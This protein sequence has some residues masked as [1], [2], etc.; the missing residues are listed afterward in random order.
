[1]MLLIILFAL[2][3]KPKV[4]N[5]TYGVSF[6]TFYAR[7]LGLNWREVYDATLD[8]LHVRQ[9]RL[10]AHWPMVEPSQG[11]Y[12][13]SELDYQMDKAAEVGAEVILAVGRRLPRWPECHVPQWVKLLDQEE[14]QKLQL[15]YMQKVIERYKNHPALKVWQVENEPFLEVYA[16]E[17]CGYFDKDFFNQEIA[18]AKKLDTEHPI[19]VTD[20][21]NLGTWHKAYKSGDMFGTSVYIYFWNPELGQFKTLLPA[22]FYRT[23]SNLMRIFYGSKPSLL[24]ELSVEPWLT[25][26]IKDTP[27]DVQFS[28]MNLQKFS[29]IIEYAKGTRFDYQYLWGVEWWYWLKLQD[30]PSFWN[31]A[32]KLY[33]PDD[34][35]TEIEVTNL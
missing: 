17:Q 10:A 5:I 24:I 32:R 8:D 31:E 29:E 11:Q 3:Y 12:N 27:L 9:L 23:K 25:K 22:W 18:L 34:K 14:R 6:N 28:R 7:E 4:K 2:S 19:L 33:D 1:M 16:F 21:G 20:S 35:K 13:F 26:P 30:K 15:E